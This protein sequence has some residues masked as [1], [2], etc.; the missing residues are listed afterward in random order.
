MNSH[1]FDLIY[2][3]KMLLLLLQL[4]L[5]Q[6]LA[7]HR[8]HHLESLLEFVQNATKELMWLNEKEEYETSRDWS[9]K[10]LNVA[11]IEAHRAV[12]DY[13]PHLFTHSFADVLND[14]MVLCF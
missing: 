1:S 13:I 9:A 11:E 5:F 12:R 4:L 6:D 7:T 8:V 14:E 3:H 10:N 2:V